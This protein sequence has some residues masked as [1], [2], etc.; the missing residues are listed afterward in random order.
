MSSQDNGG[1]T[2]QGRQPAAMP[3]RAPPPPPLKST[4][5]GA[6]SSSQKESDHSSLPNAG[7][8]GAL[9]SF[10]STVYAQEASHDG[11]KRSS[12]KDKSGS[13]FISL[14][15]SP[16]LQG[17]QGTTGLFSESQSIKSEN[18]KKG[19]A[20]STNQSGMQL[21]KG[22]GGDTKWDDDNNDGY[23]V[24]SSRVSNLGVYQNVPN[25]RTVNQPTKE[26]FG[27]FVAD[28]QNASVFTPAMKDMG[29]E[30]SHLEVEKLRKDLEQL[31][32]E[33]SEMAA[34]CKKLTS[35]CQSQQLEIREL[36][37]ALATTNASS[38][39]NEPVFQTQK[40]S[41]L[42]PQKPDQ[43]DGPIW[44]HEE[45]LGSGGLAPSEP[46]AWRALNDD[47]SKREGYK[48]PE[49]STGDVWGQHDGFISS[50]AGFTASMG[51]RQG[52]ESTTG[53]SAVYDVNSSS[54]ASH[55]FGQSQPAGW[56]GF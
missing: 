44:D 49:S 3:T 29:A 31:R 42:S 28:F 18:T 2:V 45:G 1:N 25:V 53:V 36:K 16:P 47:V 11:A 55:S 17:T 27:E 10:W 7:K 9:G 26:T 43:Q 24:Q 5:G 32:R 34:K 4:E 50:G 56:A 37:S 41:A 22:H 39:A 51:M 30:G 52:S 40:W 48:Y 46:Q 33:T 21:R 13:Q 14:T 20:A 35:I 12:A 54:R 8:G 15:K 6:F 19:G 38:Q 23:D